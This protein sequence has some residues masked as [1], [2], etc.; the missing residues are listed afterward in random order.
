MG[1]RSQYWSDDK[2]DTMAYYSGYV[3]WFLTRHYLIV[4]LSFFLLTVSCMLLCY[5]LTQRR[6]DRR[7]A[8]LYSRSL[9]TSHAQQQRTIHRD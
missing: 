4:P 7:Q 5:C 6:E 2:D 3:W 9:H 8:S 1:F